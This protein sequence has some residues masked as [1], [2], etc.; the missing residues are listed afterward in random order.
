MRQQR[1][2]VAMWI[3]GTL[4]LS[5]FAFSAP[6]TQTRK[7]VSHGVASGDVTDSTAVVWARA[8]EDTTL[9]IEYATTSEF[10]DAQNGGTMQV[11]AATDFTGTVT[12]TGLRP[13]TRYHYRVRSQGAEVATS[14]TGFF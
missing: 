7:L 14:E 11:S 3:T 12:L 1:L 13:A 10:S 5:H 8:N 6:P 4:L 2:W 9:R